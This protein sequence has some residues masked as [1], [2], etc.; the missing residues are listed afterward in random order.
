MKHSILATLAFAI[1]A[2]L[3]AQEYKNSVDGILHQLLD[4]NEKPI[5]DAIYQEIYK[6]DS[7]EEDAIF[8]AK[9]DN[10]WGWIDA[11]NKSIVPHVYHVA[12]ESRA[13]NLDGHSYLSPNHHI[14]AQKDSKWGLLDYKGK[15]VIPFD[16]DFICGDPEGEFFGQ[17]GGRIYLLGH[18]GQATGELPYAELHGFVHFNST[19]EDFHVVALVSN[20]GRKITGFS[21]L[22]KR[23]I[24]LKECI[25]QGHIYLGDN[26]GMVVRV[27]NQ[28]A[29]L[30]TFG[31]L[32]PNRYDE[33]I[34]KDAF[35]FHVR[36]DKQWGYVGYDGKEVVAPKYEAL[37]HA[38]N[39]DT[40]ETH[41]FA[42]AQDKKWL[43]LSP[44]GSQVT[45]TKYDDI[46]FGP[47]DY[48]TSFKQN[49]K[50]GAVDANGKIVIKP[51]YDAP[52]HVNPKAPKNLFPAMVGG[53]YGFID[54]NGKMIIQPQYE[55]ASEIAKDVDGYIEKG[56]KG[57]SI[58]IKGRVVWDK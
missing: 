14:P 10:K 17:K 19:P 7:G 23:E 5:P 15:E 35:G 12:D 41:A 16:Y 47:S 20:D 27:Q 8:L 11:K 2:N 39:Y 57:G 26:L 56:G 4:V 55:A 28:Y 53:L 18:D 43:L 25:G 21:P 22:Y 54:I 33:I 42:V 46:E 9:K 45:K 38:F 3:A 58:D 1:A 31:T 13:F 36:K 32:H 48:L 37:E 29:I 49:G 44:K 34:M 51:L 40:K 50:W 30:D 6:I 24:G 52:I